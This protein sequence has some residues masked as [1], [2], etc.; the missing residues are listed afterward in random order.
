M[1]CKQSEAAGHTEPAQRG[2]NT[3][4][5]CLSA[6]TC[7]SCFWYEVDQQGV[8]GINCVAVNASA[9]EMISDYQ[10]SN[11]ELELLHWTETHKSHLAVS[12][13]SHGESVRFR[14]GVNDSGDAVFSG[15]QR[16]REEEEVVQ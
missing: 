12:E 2:T 9:A 8:S 13:K 4:C 7:R 10:E 14:F 5:F 3:L 16:Q 6:K 11:V 1:C 15:A